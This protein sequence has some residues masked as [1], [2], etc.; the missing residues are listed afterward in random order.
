[1]PTLFDERTQLVPRDYQVTDLEKSFALWD[2]GEVGTL[3]R[4]FTGGGKTLMSCLKMQRW[5]SRGPEYR[6]M[7]LSYEQELVRQFAQEIE[8][9]LGITP[10]I[11]MGSEHVG[12]HD[13]PRIVVASRQSLM[14][15][16]LATHEQRDE[17]AKFGL[18]DVRLLT[19]SAATRAIQALRKDVDLQTVSDEIDRHNESYRC[20][21]ELGRVSRLY[22]FDWRDNW[23]L[24]ADEAHKYSMGMKTVG[25]LVEWFERNP[26]HRRSGVTATP[27]RR[28]KVSIGTKLFPGLALDY[29]FTKAVANGYAVPYAQKFVQVEGI[30]FKRLK[31]LCKGNQEKWDQELDRLLNTEETLA[32]LCEPLLDMVGGRKTLIFSPTVEMAQNV[33]DY[34]NARSEVECPSCGTLKWHPTRLLGDGAKCRECGDFLA[35][36]NVTRGGIQAHCLHGGIPHKSRTAVYRG[37]KDGAFQFLSICALCREGYNDPEIACVAI[38]RPVSKDASS[39]AEQMKGRGSR[40]LRGCLDG[41]NTAAERLAAIQASAKRECLIVDLVGVTGLADCA[42]TIQ[43]YA[44]GLPDELIARAEEIALTGGVENPEEAIAQAKREDAEEKERLR[45]IREEDERRR[46][47]EAERRAV[48]DARV[49]YSTHDVGSRTHAT[50]DPKLASEGQ[51]K[52]L[53][54]LGVDCQGWMPSK[55]QAGRLISLMHEGGCSPEEAIYQCGIKADQWRRARPTLK[56]IAALARQG[57]NARNMTPVEAS[58]AFARLKGN[59]LD[60]GWQASVEIN[61]AA[62]DADLDAIGRHMAQA[63]RDGMLD[64]EQMR[65]LIAAGERKRKDIFFEEVQRAVPST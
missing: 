40:P 17:L 30:D 64:G 37:H 6:C 50:G 8:D 23:L 62:T 60:I 3:T 24:V 2:G 65:K 51:L 34:I 15:H 16:E 57:V 42:S 4:C 11:E 35:A 29:P 22:K 41:I 43:I 7:V 12:E 32:K 25:H 1:M 56:Q 20:N 31:E 13:A 59:R 38:F 49:Q 39:L 27:K 5:L 21:H 55:G 53:H 61:R 58:E 47:E 63:S 26:L 10:A 44:E 19:K 18:A 14:T 36:N 9:V 46:R 33:A 54:M 45:K 52:F 28:D 48:L